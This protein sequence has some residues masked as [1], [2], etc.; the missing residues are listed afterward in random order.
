MEGISAISRLDD[1]VTFR[2]KCCLNEITNICNVIDYKDEI[3]KLFIT[4]APGIYGARLLHA[5]MPCLGA[6]LIGF[7]FYNLTTHIQKN[8]NK[9]L[10]VP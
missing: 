4:L 6:F 9:K 2:S 3:F 1:I 7:S 5:G 8:F 10:A